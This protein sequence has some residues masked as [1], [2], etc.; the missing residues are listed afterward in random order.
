MKWND[1]MESGMERLMNANSCK[2]HISIKIEVA[3]MCSGL[4]SHCRGCRSKS[5]VASIFPCLVS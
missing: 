1:G 5:S 2:W 4:L 3:I